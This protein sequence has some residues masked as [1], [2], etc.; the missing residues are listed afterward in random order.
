MERNRFKGLRVISQ[1]WISFAMLVQESPGGLISRCLLKLPGQSLFCRDRYGI[2]TLSGSFV[3]S[4]IAQCS[5][6]YWLRQTGRDRETVTQL[7][8]WAYEPHRVIT[9]RQRQA[10]DA[11]I[12]HQE[13]QQVQNITHYSTLKL[14]VSRR[15]NYV[16]SCIFVFRSAADF[17]LKCSV[18]TELYI[19]SPS[20]ARRHLNENCTLQTAMFFLHKQQ[21]NM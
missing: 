15:T 5:L 1:Q 16:L 7:V 18:I 9:E 21:A 12:P 13:I 20:T 10:T 17:K 14:R 6:I 3:R 11:E 8:L 19:V 4:V 2:S